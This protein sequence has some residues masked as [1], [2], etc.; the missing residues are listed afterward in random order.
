MLVE[1]R[2]SELGQTGQVAGNGIL[3]GSIAATGLPA[4][5]SDPFTVSVNNAGV[6]DQADIIQLPNGNFLVAW[7]SDS[8]VGVGSPAGT[9][10]I[11]RYYSP[12]G[13][14]LTPEFLINVSASAGDEGNVQLTMRPDGDFDAFYTSTLGG[15]TSIYHD[16]FRGPY[17]NNTFE[18]GP[19]APDTDA[20]LP[21]YDMPR[22]AV[23]A[24]TSDLFM[25]AY[26]KQVAGDFTV[27]TGFFSGTSGRFT[28]G[29][30]LTSKSSITGLDLGYFAD[31]HVVLVNAGTAVGQTDS[32]IF[33]NML[34][35]P[36]TLNSTV[37]PFEIAG[38]GTDGA[39]DTQPVVTGLTGG[40]FA[41]SYVR[42]IG[43]DSDVVVATF[44]AAG[45]LLSS[46]AVGSLGGADANTHPS[47]TSLTDG[48]FAVTFERAGAGL[49]VAHFS[50]AGNLLGTLDYAP[51]GS[52]G[53]STIALADGR[54][55]SVYH[56]ADGNISLEFLDARTAMTPFIY[57]GSSSLPSQYG[58]AVDDV[59]TAKTGALFVYGGPG[60]DV[61]TETV[62]SSTY[63]GTGNDT[64]IAASGGTHDGGAGVDTID[65]SRLLFA[66][67]T[68]DLQA[69]KLTAL[70]NVTVTMANFENL[71][72]TA[73]PDTIIGSS[74]A[75]RLSGGAGNDLIN[76]ADGD[77]Y[78]DGGTGNDRLTGDAGTDVFGFNDLGSGNDVITDF[79]AGERIDLSGIHL[80]DWATLQPYM[81]QS[82]ANTVI[83]FY[84]NSTPQTITIENTAL[85]SLTA[86]DFIFDSAGTPANVTGS[87]GD[88][89]LFGGAGNNSINGSLGADT[90]I[91]GGGADI[92]DG[93]PDDDLLTGGAGIDIFTFG[94]GFGRD[95]I[96]DFSTDGIDLS[97]LNITEFNQ[98]R[99][100]LYQMGADTVFSI[101]YGS[102]PETITFKN[103]DISALNPSSVQVTVNQVGSSF[104]STGDDVMFGTSL[105]GNT[106]NDILVGTDAFNDALSGEGGNDILYGGMGGDTLD[107]G[108]GSDTAA[109]GNS[110]AAVNVNLATSVGSGGA[111]QGDHYISIENLQ[112]SSFDD[113]L[114]G[115]NGANQ[116]DGGGGADQLRG[117]LGDDI[118][119]IDNAGDQAFENA[120]EG[121]DTVV[122]SIGYYLFP[123]FETLTLA[124]GAGDI[125]GVGNELANV[126]TGNEGSN[127]LIA[128]VGDDTVRGGAG[129]DSLFGQDGID[130]LYGD[131]GIDFLVGGYGDDVLDGGT[132]AD[133]LYGEDG[134]DT[135]IGGA[136]FATD[137]LVGGY[138]NDVLHGDSGLGDYDLMDGGAGDDVYYVDTPAD[139]TFEAVGGGTD[140]VYANIVGAGYYLYA[141]VENLVLLGTTP[142]GVGNELDN[143]LTGNAVGNYLLG[144]AGND[145]LNGK[146]GND[147]LFGESGADTFI[148]EH[149]TGGDVIGD[150]LAGTDKIDLSAFGFASYQTVVNSMHEVNGTTAIDL[151]GSDFIILNG[152]PEA[153]LHAGDF[154]LSVGSQVIQLEARISDTSAPLP[155][156]WRAGFEHHF[157]P[158]NSYMTFDDVRDQLAGALL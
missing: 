158:P 42:I 5:W 46:V 151:G 123:N 99:P 61:I 62:S 73:N 97:R 24:K 84:Y 37:V 80:A 148:F 43:G 21:N 75:N 41:V 93:G 110:P 107:G 94:L 16:A 71:I 27:V 66:S 95:V 141:N 69:G 92:L 22:L 105:S 145:V 77:D 86:A 25:Y 137:I 147:V 39:L 76:G 2:E 134:A 125:Y 52:D 8:N 152:V 122:A 129:V 133:A 140:M 60:D 54:F 96:T 154:I 117:G 112:G 9:D 18:S 1:D 36:G 155:G 33:V 78:L 103:T 68:F 11:G 108:T 59:F 128:G 135:L 57:S 111:A 26:E 20:A 146:G 70:T 131:A 58:T 45:T 32:A 121:S 31:G 53:A 47:I 132:D 50:A 44:N 101:F 64:L 67:A 82:G 51:A 143:R 138:G 91:A 48:S 29:F 114:I 116:L 150:F 6:Q 87:L 17:S 126:I 136:D 100:F 119:V 15:V 127:L 38:T 74:V 23:L 4:V 40:G 56:D 124:T 113:I 19:I 88:D 55:A 3:L 130:H 35:S 156:G 7:R 81:S 102:A 109:Y 153:S 10:I 14:P 98:L 115:T 72:G 104:G 89:L 142:Y 85:A 118:Y 28:N 139:L 34:A 120:G 90:I 106:G 12:N 65:W 79:T 63:G 83:S 149:G 144:G 30:I 13:A 49:E 157:D